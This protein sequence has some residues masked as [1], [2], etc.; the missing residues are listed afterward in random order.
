M[1]SHFVAGIFLDRR[2]RRK[3]E[4]GQCLR[5]KKVETFAAKIQNTS[6]KSEWITFKYD[7]VLTSLNNS[8]QVQTSLNKSKQV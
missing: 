5:Q 8:K 1:H 3:L 6:G 4:T 7:Q 2:G